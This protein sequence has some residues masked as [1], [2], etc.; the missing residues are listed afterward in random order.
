MQALA[1][2]AF[3]KQAQVEGDATQAF[4]LRAHPIAG[5]C[6]GLPSMICLKQLWS[7]MQ[8]LQVRLKAA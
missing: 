3:A 6:E 2:N 7:R 4:W 5:C 8:V 1:E